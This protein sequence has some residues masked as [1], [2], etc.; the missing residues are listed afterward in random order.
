MIKKLGSVL[1]ACLISSGALACEPCS[2]I[3]TLEQTATKADTIVIGEPASSDDALS[4][5]RP[6]YIHVK[7]QRALKG[8]Q[9][10]K[11][12]KV[13]SW[14]GICPFGIQFSRNEKALIFLSKENDHY[15][16]VDDGCAER[17][18]PII[19]GVISIQDKKMAVDEF[20]QHYLK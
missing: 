9:V 10:D 15:K 5:S 19:N 2:S 16:S 17:Q 3:L 18:V 14:Y 13:R 6:E 8:K 7:V 12:I 1:I 11:V 4:T 20:L